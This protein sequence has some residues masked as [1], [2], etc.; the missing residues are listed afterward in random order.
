MSASRIDR[1]ALLTIAAVVFGLHALALRW[2]AA[3]WGAHFYAFLPPAAGWTAAGLV[4]AAAVP[5]LRR[6][7][8]A[9]P[10]DARPP[11]EPVIGNV[12]P[13]RERT[14]VPRAALGGLAIAAA[15]A[16][17]WTFR[18]RH[19]L[20]GDGIPLTARL[21]AGERFHDLEPLTA[22]IQHALYQF[23]HARAGGGLPDYQVAWNAVAAG[24]ALA[25]GLFVPVAW[26]LAGELAGGA[27]DPAGAAAPPR[28][29]RALV[30][31]LLLAQGYVQLFFGYVENYTWYTLAA[32][33][34]LLL[35]VRWLRGRGSL[36]PAGAALLLA[37]ALH[38]SAGVLIP[39][40]AALALAGL[41]RGARRGATLRDLLGLALLFLGVSAAFAWLA[42][43][44]AL[45]STFLDVA[46]RALGRGD[47]A[48]AGYLLSRAH[49]RDFFNEQVLIGPLA[50]PLF[51][52]ALA[53]ARPR[54]GAATWFA[55]SA[56]LAYLGASWVAGDSNLGYARNW[57]LLAPGALVMLCAALLLARERR[58]ASHADVG[59]LVLAATLSLAHTVPWIAVNADEPRA[60]RRFA[61]LPLGLGRTETTLGL[62]QAIRGHPAEAERWWIRSLDLNPAN[63]RAHGFL[64]ELYLKDGRVALACEAFGTAV[65]LRPDK[66]EYRLDLASALTLAGRPGDARVE[67]E[68]LLRA[69]PAEPSL[70][71]LDGVLLALVGD[72]P[73][74]RVALERAIEHADG[75]AVYARARSALDQ[76][77]GPARL[78]EDWFEM[79]ARAKSAV[80]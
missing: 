1:A 13:A 10:A 17:F 37:L 36:L 78:R 75:A 15:V 80:P 46:A 71:G 49:V 19:I 42:P 25:G 27:R 5:L 8:A 20:L 23:A 74:A 6:V 50:L 39:S 58:D 54:D 56:G 72:L 79:L 9:A 53:G 34:Y 77:D 59:A 32:G 30:F 31:V 76:P 40:F 68:R 66:V 65:R 21:P 52:V 26:A 67:I 48:A 61:V 7:P 44:Y 62:W 4:I 28:A 51:A 2:T 55:A 60:L 24:S 38:L 33:L 11:A 69:H 73:D 12:A 64:G 41:A 29:A 3:L 18:I 43:G 63:V 57:D 45:T 35:A 47:A 14:G 22:L 70:W 16:L